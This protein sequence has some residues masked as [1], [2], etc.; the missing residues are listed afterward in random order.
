MAAPTAQ[1][2]APLGP[3]LVVGSLRVYVP[4]GPRVVCCTRVWCVCTHAARR[5]WGMGVYH[6]QICGV[7]LCAHGTVCVCVVCAL[8]GRVCSVCVTRMWT[9]MHMH[10]CM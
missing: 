1:G 3:E 4:E 10:V 7:H 6:M 9:C 5:P 2:R 8:C